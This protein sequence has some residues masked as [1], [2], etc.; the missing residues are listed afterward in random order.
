MK[1]V[2]RLG[3]VMS[4]MAIWAVLAIGVS[5][6]TMTETMT[7]YTGI[8]TDVVGG[9]NTQLQTIIPIALGVVAALFFAKLGFK[10]VKGW[11]SKA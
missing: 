4:A 5:A 6:Q 8:L 7:V 11:L 9:V 3:V 10:T 2:R 1:W